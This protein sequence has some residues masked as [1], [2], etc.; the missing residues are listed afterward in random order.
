[1]KTQRGFT[2]IEL[3]IVVAIIGILASVA[4]PAY[5]DYIIRGKLTEATSALS[6]ARIKMEQS[7]QDNRT[8]N[9]AGDG[10]T[11]PA[12]IPA[13][14]TNFTYACSGLST[15]AYTITATGRNNLS[16]FS[17]TINQENKKKTTGLKSG[18]GTTPA[19]CWITRSG[20]RC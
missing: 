4:L 1:M 16:A 13:S 17:Y 11:C 15:T 19:D 7:F 12:G 3:I 5:N 14:S 18:W 6:D 20:D 8:Y 9:S 10:T 2:L